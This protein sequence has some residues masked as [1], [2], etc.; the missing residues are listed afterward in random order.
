[1]NVISSQLHDRMTEERYVV[2]VSSFDLDV[3]V[4]GVKMVRIMEEG[5]AALEKMN[6][7]MGLGF[8]EFDLDFYTELFQV[9]G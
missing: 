4:K 3:E 6:G 9:G 5:R 1:M 7:E 2:P 8:D